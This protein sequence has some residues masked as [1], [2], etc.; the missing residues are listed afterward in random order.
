MWVWRGYQ[1][2]MIGDTEQE[3]GATCLLC[4]RVCI[5]SL[6]KWEPVRYFK[7]TLDTLSN[8]L[9]KLFVLIYNKKTSPKVFL[10]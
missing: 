2:V 9:S 3:G 5:L 10:F 1:E 4:Q 8:L 7:Q 6:S